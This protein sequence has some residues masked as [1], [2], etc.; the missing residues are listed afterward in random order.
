MRAALTGL[1]SA[2][3]LIGFSPGAVVAAEELSEVGQKSFAGLS[4][5]VAESDTLLV[6]L[7]VD[8]SGSLQDTDPENLRVDG[9]ET[10]IAALSTLSESAD[11]AIDVQMSLA[12]FDS[13]YEELVGW[14]SLTAGHSETMREAAQQELPGRN[15]G[16][17]T[18]YR[19]ALQGAQ[20]SLDTRR[21][22]VDPDACQVVLWFTDGK[23]AVDGGDNAL[24]QQ[25]LCTTN[26]I[27]DGIRGQEVTVI[28]LGLF[29]DEDEDTD[30]LRAVAESSGEV[31]TCGT[32]PVP[33]SHAP[34]A[35]LSAT[36]A[37]ALSLVFAGAGAR[38]EGGQQA[39]RVECPGEE[40]VDGEFPVP[41]DKGLTGFRL[42]IDGVDEEAP[43]L[44]EAPDGSSVELVSG[45]TMFGGGE[46]SVTD[47]KGL[48]VVNI[49]F[50]SGGSPGGAWTLR[51]N[52]A[53]GQITVVDLYYFWGARLAV[54]APDGLVVGTSSPL[55]IT[56]RYPDGTPVDSAAFQSLI[57]TAEVA[58]EDI[59]LSSVGE[60]RFTGHYE[61]PAEGGSSAVDVAVAARAVSSPSNVD[62]GPVSAASS[63]STSLPPSYAT[64]MT[65][66]LPL[67]QIVG[68]GSAIG[69]L[70]FQGSDRGPTE[71]CLTGASAVG[72][73]LAGHIDVVVGDG[74]E[75]LAVPADETIQWPVEVS[76]SNAADGRL[77]GALTLRMTG[78]GAAEPISLQV[79]FDA[80]MMRP[81]NEPLRWGLVALLV[82]AGLLLPLV[83]L[84]LTN[85]LTSGF[86]VSSRTH[87][88]SVPVRLGPN[89]LVRSGGQRLVLD[90]FHGGFFANQQR[91][92]RVGGPGEA[93][94]V[95]RRLPIWPLSEVGYEAVST[96]PA[97]VVLSNMSPFTRTNGRTAPATSNLRDD[98]FLLL[99]RSEA[100]DGEF[101]GDLVFFDE[102]D[103]DISTV[104]ARREEQFTR[105]G[106]WAQ[107]HEKVTKILEA[108]Q[109]APVQDA[110]AVVGGDR[111]TEGSSEREDRPSLWGGPPDH[112]SSEGER[113]SGH[114]WDASN[115]PTPSV[116]R[117]RPGEASG[118]P[119]PP[120]RDDDPDDRPPSIF[121]N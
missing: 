55:E 115:E 6:S 90:D 51:T 11:D 97:R 35:Y 82:G 62:L 96:S 116:E 38:I 105:F 14:G 40:C 108:E 34:G 77:D 111:S 31:M 87:R 56:L 95:R 25:E 104:I 64:L 43:P 101:V 26:G 103:P 37:G 49:D 13:S 24:A 15:T 66:Q 58:G 42:L 88:V 70:E 36:D 84:W 98:F 79:P 73:E 59:A 22:E 1:L 109:T 93:L 76:P 75:C 65:P 21:G 27:M 107:M 45:D 2:A 12:V 19:A 78:V 83:I 80:S 46:L 5:C 85:F 28:A 102:D 20:H 110:V 17:Y 9:V 91:A 61:V 113:P 44:L 121:G 32:T 54:Q 71:V 3:L 33:E 10:A 100:E 92:N 39:L 81:V 29:A 112:G 8:Q 60:G 117:Y 118:G 30:L 50:P 67:E 47:P 52:A 63:M 41:L 99:S 18:D 57:V 48:S 86:L 114:L 7:V 53:G 68:D 89:G 16:D 72:P 69:L 106:D 74:V 94:E 119:R 120:V 4:A 23:L